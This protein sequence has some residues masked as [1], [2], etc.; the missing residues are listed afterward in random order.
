MGRKL[1][2]KTLKIHQTTIRNMRGYFQ[3]FQDCGDD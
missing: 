3:T 2:K 1:E